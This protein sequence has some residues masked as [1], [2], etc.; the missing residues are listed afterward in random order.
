[1]SFIEE[2]NKIKS[3]DKVVLFKNAFPIVPTW[4]EFDF[5]RKN[6]K[7]PVRW[8]NPDL[9]VSFETLGSPIMSEFESF[10]TFRDILAE[11]WGWQLWDEPALIM[12]TNLEAVSGLGAHFDPC[13]QI[14]WNCIGS[15]LWK[16]YEDDYQTVTEEFILEPGDVIFLPTGRI[17]G[18]S[19]ITTPRAGIAFSVRSEEHR[20]SHWQG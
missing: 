6:N 16:I 18:V 15:T 17:H 11:I 20:N 10:K 9:T 5:Q 13:E 7:R 8:D 19:S 12:A 4:E 2:F 1:M 14:H 3:G